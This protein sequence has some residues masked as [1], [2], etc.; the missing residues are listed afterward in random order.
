MG[1]DEPEVGDL[2]RVLA[3]LQPV[4]KTLEQYDVVVTTF[5]TV[6]SE[7]NTHQTTIKPVEVDSDD[8][9][10]KDFGRKTLKKKSTKPLNALFEVKWHRVVVGE[11]IYACMV[12]AD[13]LR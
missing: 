8:S 2:L 11:Y 13:I 10:D 12:P 4:A 5:Q 9:S 7:Y 6:A 1:L 3:N